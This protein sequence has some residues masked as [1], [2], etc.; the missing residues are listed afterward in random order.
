[1]HS[2]GDMD[3]QRGDEARTSINDDEVEIL[4]NSNPLISD[5][6]ET[7]TSVKA[8]SGVCIS[9][10]IVHNVPERNDRPNS[11]SKRQRAQSQLIRI[12]KIRRKQVSR[13]KKVGKSRQ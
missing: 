9:P 1:M 12:V 13:A 6:T 11:D 3:M 8:T 4:N 10:V 2:L 7:D 5:A